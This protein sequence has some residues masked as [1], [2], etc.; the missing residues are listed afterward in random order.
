[1]EEHARRNN[2]PW[3]E[4]K[5][6]ELTR[7]VANAAA[8]HAAWAATWGS[9]EDVSR[10][11]DLLSRAN[12]RADATEGNVPDYLLDI[13]DRHHEAE[14][15]IE[16]AIAERRERDGSNTSQ[17]SPSESSNSGSSSDAD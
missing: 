13:I 1:M 7:E 15:R 12:E 8:E 4:E 3:D 9:P 16:A 6:A 2:M 17:S 11:N 14:A 5:N 10:A